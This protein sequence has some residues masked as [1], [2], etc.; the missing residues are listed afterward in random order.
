MLQD[1]CY[2]PDCQNSDAG[3]LLFQPAFKIVDSKTPSSG[4]NPGVVL[5]NAQAE[6]E[7]GFCFMGFVVIYGLID[8]QTLRLRYIGKAKDMSGRARNHKGQV[9]VTI[10]LTHSPIL[11]ILPLL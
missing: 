7:R 4:F 2:T 11:D 10:Y 5:A 8:P 1:F 6:F 3:L 9:R